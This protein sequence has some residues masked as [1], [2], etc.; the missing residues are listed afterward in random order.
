MVSLGGTAGPLD[1]ATHRGRILA[2]SA[3]LSFDLEGMQPTRQR[4]KR[5]YQQQQILVWN[6]G[7]FESGA[8]CVSLA[9]RLLGWLSLMKFSY[10][11]ASLAVLVPRP[12]VMRLGDVFPSLSWSLSFRWSAFGW[13]AGQVLSDL[14][15]YIERSIWITQAYG[16]GMGT[17]AEG[18]QQLTFLIGAALL[19]GLMLKQAERLPKLEFASV[20]IAGIGLIFLLD[21]AH[22][23][24][25]GPD[26]SN[27][28][29][30]LLVI[31]SYLIAATMRTSQRASKLLLP[32]LVLGLA[33]CTSVCHPTIGTSARSISESKGLIRSC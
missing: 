13:L 27:E 12:F 26:R 17:W 21:K 30:S 3:F 9:R 2:D 28:A 20:A 4:S 22:F 15:T 23:F 16:Q 14:P 24:R 31:W 18:T 19:L 5:R 29:L 8:R 33:T 6:I 32:A 1:L 25:A 7:K 10:L 11:I